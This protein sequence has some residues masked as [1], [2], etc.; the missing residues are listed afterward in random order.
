[1]NLRGLGNGDACPKCVNQLMW[2]LL[3]HSSIAIAYTLQYN[4]NRVALN[5]LDYYGNL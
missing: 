3:A 5:L 2:F 4:T 1:M